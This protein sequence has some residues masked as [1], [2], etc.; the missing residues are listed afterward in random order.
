MKCHMLPTDQQTLTDWYRL[1]NSGQWLSPCL[2]TTG[3]H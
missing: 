1:L 3:L 2:H